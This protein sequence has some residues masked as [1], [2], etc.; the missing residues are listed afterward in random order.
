VEE[1][2]AE[3]GPVTA[4]LHGAGRNQPAPLASLDEPAFQKT[5]APKIEGLETIVA[6]V[7]PAALK[8]LVTFGSIIG[9]AGLRGQADYAT[10]NDW[11]TDLTRQIQ[12]Q[13]PQ[14]R[15]LALEW[16]VWS[17]AG[18]G[19]KLGVLESLTRE[20]IS[21]ISVDDGIAILRR[22]L[23]SRCLPTS[24]VVMGRA[25][26][27]PTIALESC[28][29]PLMRFIDRPRVYYPGIEL[30]AEAELCADTDPYL[31]DHL[32]DG[33]LLFPAVLGMEAMAQAA[34]AL[35]GRAGQ[36]V[37]E[38][39][40]FL[41]PIVVPVDGSATIRVAALRRDD[42]VDVAIRSSDTGFAADHFRATLRYA[43]D[44]PFGTERIP[45]PAE[46]MRVP[47]DPARDLYGGVFFQGKRFQRVVGYRRLAATSCAV[48]ISAESGDEWF[49]SYLPRE[50][51]LGN[52]G[53]RDA[54]M[55]GIQCCVPNATLLPAGVERLYPADP[56][57]R[58]DQVVLHAAERDRVGDT[59]TYDLDVCSA[60]GKIIERWEGLRLQAVRK[61]DGRGPWIP[62]LLGPYLERQLAEML[63]PA[64]RCVVEPDPP[65]CVGGV[66]SRRKQTEVAVSRML[67]R[68][69]AVSHRGDGK[70]E[71]V[72]EETGVSA[73]HGA[74]VT[75]A[76]VG[77]ERVACD[78]E[79]V[80]DRTADDWR[81]LLDAEQFALAELIQRERGEELSVAAT[82]V[83]G[84]V[85]CLRKTGRALAGPVTLANGGP[86]GWV[87]LHSGQAKIATFSARLRD[88]PDPVVFTILT[89]GGDNGSVLRISARGWLRGDQPRGERLLRQ[90]CALAGPVP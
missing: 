34:A 62:A 72:A 61:T 50:L 19:E 90:L 23:A 63:P 73:S 29:L 71:V 51:L 78:A 5:L 53:T 10:A 83:W 47:L 16:S 24:L 81:A 75:L 68:P 39:V 77:P 58:S 18:M 20:G 79:A 89:E 1:V 76:V 28:E 32:L 48:E 56:A 45:A 65:A 44:R 54:F 7:D 26:G 37:F 4:I 46:G 59:Y 70:P 64:P 85:E 80:S 35:A 49:G 40:E 57:E 55:H 43:G 31:T 13:H 15:C 88:E 9:R 17:G 8:L 42:R 52:P 33:D 14:C 41:R 67:E 11:L 30:V 12:S 27:L 38:N 36:P 3:L 82:R 22:L 69:A 86:V 66:A 84:A 2:T 60:D 6:A 25:G 21:P 74:G 87:L